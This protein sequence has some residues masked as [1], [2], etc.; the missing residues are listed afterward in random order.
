MANN[1]LLAQETSFSGSLSSNWTA[2]NSLL[3][4]QVVGGNTRPNTLSVEA[5]QIYTGVTPPNDHISEMTLGTLTAETTSNFQLC[6]RMQ[7]GA[8]SGYKAAFGQGAS[9][10][11]ATIYRMDAGSA[12]ALTTTNDNT[13]IAAFAVGD[14]WQLIAAGSVISLYQN[15][16]RVA[17]AADETYTNG[18]Y[19]FLQFSS[20]DITHTNGTSW[21]GYNVIQQDGIW[22]KKGVII[23]L[24]NTDIASSGFGV[25]N[26][27]NIIY[28]GNA[29]L[30]SG[31]V[32]KMWFM[33][34]GNSAGNQGQSWY[35]ESTDGISWTQRGSAVIANFGIQ[36]LVKFGSTYYAWGQDGTAQGS[37]NVKV[38]T[39]SDGISWTL[40]NS[41]FLS[42]GSAGQWDAGNLYIQCNP[43]IINGT[44][45]FLYGGAPSPNSPV[46]FA[47]GIATSPDGITTAT[48]NGA[49]PVLNPAVSGPLIKV[50]NTFYTWTA[51]GPG[52]NNTRFS[53]NAFNPAETV[54]CSSTDMINWSATRFRSMHCSQ[55]YESVDDP[56]GNATSCILI[57]I[58]G[59]CY[60]YYVGGPSDSV[61]PQYYQISLATGPTTIAN[62]VTQPEDG[63]S[64][65]NTD[66]FPG[67][68]GDLNSSN[69]A[70]PVGGTKLTIVSNRVR[71]TSTGAYNIMRYI[72]TTPS[73]VALPADHYSQITVPTLTDASSFAVLGVRIQSG[74]NSGYIAQIQGAFGTLQVGGSGILKLTNGTAATFPWR[75]VPI[76]AAAGDVFRLSVAT[77]NN[78]P[79]ISLF[80][81]GAMVQQ[82]VDLAN[83]YPTG[84]PGIGVNTATLANTELTTFSDGS[85][86]VLPTYSSGVAF[87][88][89]FQGRLYV[90]RVVGGL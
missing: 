45:Y 14:V 25:W 28:E 85:A 38:Y 12:T 18:F 15:G 51:V 83:T 27:S 1:G 41:N 75:T 88:I 80:Q 55:L 16:T 4:C 87:D 6:V 65:S 46:S 50:G 5:G 7:S 71:A 20:T 37:G 78:L 57:D 53:G 76:R 36:S 11:S 49:N 62:I 23:P 3:K 21:R 90:S 47:S 54:R 61:A 29:Q 19:G 52:P 74:S 70:T 56:H 2:I 66:S 44:W 59:V 64:Q 17:Y 26:I 63:T 24:K 81:N 67:G 33:R 89:L 58:G 86:G 35:A 73:G 82:C 10:R 48:K 60:N 9:T 8:Y 77:V 79:T 72:G 30:L 40:Q 84:A 42:L 31:T 39:S 68:N 34:G 13:I 32:F 69:W 22:T 43:V